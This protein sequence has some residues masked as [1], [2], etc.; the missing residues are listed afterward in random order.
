[1]LRY[2]LLEKNYHGRQR[3]GERGGEG[4]GEQD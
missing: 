3:E 4:K 1:M 2:T